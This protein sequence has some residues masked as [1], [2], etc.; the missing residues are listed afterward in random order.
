MLTASLFTNAV[1][2]YLLHDVD[3]DMVGRLNLAYRELMREF[4]FFAIVATVIFL[5]AGWLG[6]LVLRLKV[7]SAGPRLAF[8]LGVTTILI[9]YPA[10]FVARLLNSGRSSDS[11]LL[12]YLLLVPACSAG[13]LVRDAYIR[14]S[15]DAPSVVS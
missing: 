3:A 6:S 10:E 11:F 1:A 15:A 5:L 8:V 2:V 9:Q 7:A 12:A 4:V 14:Q 13:I